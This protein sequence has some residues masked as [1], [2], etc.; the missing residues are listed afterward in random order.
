M[1][2]YNQFSSSVPVANLAESA[3]AIFIKKTYFHL[4]LAVLAFTILQFLLIQTGLAGLIWGIISSLGL[5]GY[6]LFI[7]AFVGLSAVATAM[8]INTRSKPMQ[9]FGLGIY[10]ALEAVVI[11]PL[12][13]MATSIDSGGENTLLS[14]V[15]FTLI[16]VFA[17]S[18]IA[19]TSKAN[20]SFLGGFLAIGSMIIL[21]IIILGAIFG[22]GLGLWFSAGM[23]FFAGICLLYETSNVVHNYREDQYIVAALALFASIATIFY[24]ILRLFIQLSSISKE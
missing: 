24:Y 14:A 19:L 11:S 21:G 10:T 18:F 1:S 9:Y 20:F 5:I 12:I 13:I 3:R 16:L 23:V 7:G 2:Q 8:T 4:A 17:L 15:V 6:L 22:F